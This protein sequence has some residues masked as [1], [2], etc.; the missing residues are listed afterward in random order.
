WLA[1]DVVGWQHEHR[2]GRK[3]SPEAAARQALVYLGQAEGACRPTKA[4]YALRS[5]CRKALGEEAAA[6]ADTQRADQ[7]PATMALDHF[8]R[9]QAAHN[10]NQLAEA[11]QAFE[12]ARRLEPAHYWSMMWLGS[13]LCDLGRRP[14]DFIGAARVFTGCILRRPD[15]A[16]AYHCRA[17]AYFELCR[18]EE[19][20]A[21]YSKANE[22]DPKHG[23]A[24]GRR[25]GAYHQRGPPGEGLA[26]T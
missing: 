6:Q 23:R 4:F 24:W 15:H 1:A 3:L 14:E 19:A 20:A 13:C 26:R 16:H 2:S 8:L 21:D 5:R 7:T 18:W 12:A 22:L 17:N 9:G 11:V 25:G 10:V